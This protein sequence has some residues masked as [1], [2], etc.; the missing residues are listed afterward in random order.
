MCVKIKMNELDS[1][2]TMYIDL[3]LL[4]NKYIDIYK[5]ARL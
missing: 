3:D 2:D 1:E 5:F 4:Q